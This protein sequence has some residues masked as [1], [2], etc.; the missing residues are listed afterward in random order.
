[1]PALQFLF[2]GNRP[3][4]GERPPQGKQRR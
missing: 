4:L 2:S 1:M 3:T